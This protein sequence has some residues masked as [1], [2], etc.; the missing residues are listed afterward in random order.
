VFY[1]IDILT[2][3]HQLRYYPRMWDI[4]E[5]ASELNNVTID[6][7]EVFAPRVDWTWS[8]PRKHSKSELLGDQS[9]EDIQKKFK[10]VLRRVPFMGN[11]WL[12]HL[13]AIVLGLFLFFYAQF[14]GPGL[15]DLA[16]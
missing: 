3:R 12:P 11:V 10:E 1:I 9:N 16:L 13:V 4:E 6:K 7:R 2:K 14:N 8:V 15:K 5:A